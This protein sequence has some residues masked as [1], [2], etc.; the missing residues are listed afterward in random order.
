MEKFINDLKEILEIEDRDI[1][2]ADRFRDYEEWD[3]LAVLS[4]LAM[5]NDEFDITIK[6]SELDELHTVQQLYDFILKRS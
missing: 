2:P 1:N 3:S 4:V 5:I 6:R